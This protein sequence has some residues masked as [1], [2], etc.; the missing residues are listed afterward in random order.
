MS[1][2]Q[3][4]SLLPTLFAQIEEEQPLC[5][6][7]IGGALPETV[8]F[9]S[10]YRC[11]L[12]FLDLFSDLGQ[13]QAERDPPVSRRQLLTD[14]LPL[15][16]DTRFDLCLFWDLFNFMDADSISDLVAVLRPHLHAGTLAHGFAVHN[17]K[18]PQSGQIYGIRELDQLSLRP[19]PA[20]LPGYCPHN[21]GQL[22]KLLDC[23][24]FSRSVLLPGSRL[25]MLLKA[26]L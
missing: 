5:V 17:L 16:A 26:R 22:E 23:F 8:E 3:P 6:L 18:T 1:S 21:Q 2:S 13:L 19:R 20:E 4:S 25:E 11:K 9:F 7:H 10:R 12:H 14:W 24:S 15:S